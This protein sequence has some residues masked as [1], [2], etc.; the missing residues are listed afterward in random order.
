[1]PVLVF[2]PCS[3]ERTD[4]VSIDL[5]CGVR[6]LQAIE[7]VNAE[8]SPVPVGYT[9]L[10]RH[11]DESIH[12]A[13]VEFLGSDIPSIG[14]S[15]FYIKPVLQA[16]TGDVKTPEK[17]RTIE[18]EFYRVTFAEDGSRIESLYDKELGKELALQAKTSLGPLEFE[19]GTFE[20]F[21]VG[22][23]LTVPDQSYFEN[24]EHEGSGESVE[25][26]GELFRAGDSPAQISV[27]SSG[28]F[29]KTLT[30]EGEFAGSKRRQKVVLYD[31]LK[32]I[33]LHVELEW[34]GRSNVA[35]YVQM[36][37]ALMNGKKYIDV[38]FAVHADG[39][40][41]T[42]FW[43]DENLP[44]KFKIR[45]VQDWLCFEEAGRGLAIATRWP[46]IDLTSIPSFPLLWTNDDSGFF[47]G[48]RYQQKGNHRFS[49]SL[50]SYKG[51]WAE[52]EVYLW[53][54]QWARPLLTYFG[55]NS[56]EVTHDSYLSVRPRNILLSA[57]KKAQEEDAVVLRFYETAGK[58]TDA[59]VVTSFQFQE[60][61]ES[62][63]TETASK[64]LAA[65]NNTIKLR[66]RPYEIKTIKLTL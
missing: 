29:S 17:T 6:G 3:W 64:K 46:V 35:V 26:T 62:N 57:F 63:I 16:K 23:R 40:E 8:N 15:T 61:R 28:N 27:T 2:N 21:G 14:Y 52:N 41:L 47:F 25:P 59:E 31:G 20:L 22:L 11:K 34:S 10:E 55:D 44:V 9:V 54:K 37:T 56:T 50:T 42:D 51:S 43:L 33:D 36:P 12:K 7:V 4:V 19:F 1:M 18:N 5:D 39:N 60:A 13:T 24:P 58:K 45:G 48:E 49:F 53:G 65:N 32:R 38:P 66:F 30:A